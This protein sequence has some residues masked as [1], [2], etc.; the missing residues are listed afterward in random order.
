MA[1]TTIDIPMAAAGELCCPQILE[2]NLSD[3]D[4]RAAAR[5]FKALGDPARVRLLSL[6]ASAPAGEACVCE[7]VDALDLAQ[8]TVSHHLRQLLQAGLVERERRGTW[9]YY[10][11]RPEALA[12]V[13]RS[14]E[15]PVGR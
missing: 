3:A 10:R 12:A 6:I 9:A 13:S 11:A 15:L 1:Q 8:P 7:L 14:L 5:V 4:A 2:S